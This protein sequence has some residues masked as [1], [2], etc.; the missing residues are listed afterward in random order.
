[1]SDAFGDSSDF[2]VQTSDF[3]PSSNSELRTPNCYFAITPHAALGPPL[4]PA[5]GSA[6]MPSSGFA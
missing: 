3:C 4:C 5:L 6:V 1:M 2:G